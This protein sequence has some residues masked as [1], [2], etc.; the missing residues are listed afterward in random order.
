MRVLQQG[1]MTRALSKG[2]SI[3]NAVIVCTAAAAAVFALFV[4]ATATAGTTAASVQPTADYVVAEIP[5]AFANGSRAIVTQVAFQVCIQLGPDN[6]ICNPA[7]SPIGAA[8]V[9][10]T[11]WTDASTPDGTILESCCG[12]S[13]FDDF[14]AKVIDGIDDGVALFFADFGFPASSGYGGYESYF[15]GGGDLSGFVIHRIGFRVDALS[16][17]SPGSDPNGDG[18]WTDAALQGTV[19]FEG[20]IVRSPQSTADCKHGG[21]Q[22]LQQ[23]DGTSF[24]NQGDCVSFVATGGKH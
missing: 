8:S 24:K 6:Y 20:T 5:V 23:P 14:V 15:F 11:I 19:L 22:E 16:L 10:T 18:L 9:G 13:G 7:F 21:W 2:S 3:R 4:G 12:I 1:R 17:V